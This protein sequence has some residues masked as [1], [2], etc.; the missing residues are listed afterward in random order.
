M[1]IFVS[2]FLVFGTGPVPTSTFKYNDNE[3]SLKFNDGLAYGT[4]VFRGK[5]VK[6]PATKRDKKKRDANHIVMYLP[7][8]ANYIECC[9]EYNIHPSSSSVKYTDTNADGNEVYSTGNYACI[10]WNVDSF[11]EYNSVLQMLFELNAKNIEGAGDIPAELS[12]NVSGL[13]GYEFLMETFTKVRFSE[14]AK[15]QICAN[16]IFTLLSQT[17][18]SS[19]ECK[20]TW[21]VDVNVNFL[22]HFMTKPGQN[23]G[24]KKPNNSFHLK[25][26]EG[27]N[28]KKYEPYSYDSSA[29]KLTAFAILKPEFSSIG[30]NNASKAFVEFFGQ[31]D[32]HTQ[33]RAVYVNPPVRF[34]KTLPQ[35]LHDSFRKSQTLSESM[36]SLIK[37]LFVFDNKTSRYMATDDLK[38]L[39]MKY[40]SAMPTVTYRKHNSDST[41]VTERCSWSRALGMLCMFC[42]KLNERPADL[43]KNVTIETNLKNQERA[44][45]AFTILGELYVEFMT[46][47]YEIFASQDQLVE[48]NQP[49]VAEANQPEVA[50]ADQPEVAKA[51]QPEVAEAVQTDTGDDG[52]DTSEEEDAEELDAEQPDAE[53]PDASTALNPRIMALNTLFAKRLTS[54]LQATH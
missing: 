52:E 27:P 12:S 48:A 50:K 18:I 51:D 13:K 25:E 39:V 21:A 7:F 33:K 37:D 40:K 36:K 54:L 4:R 38:A 6:I 17:E 30:F 35:H 42:S 14:S 8:C 24:R 1:N 23:V 34:S 41:L 47:A 29:W 53:Q 44:L 46:G 49:E 5:I 10:E 11:D 43:P 45:K 16:G 9:K 3:A 20:Q 31:D 32:G 2:I 15:E 28:G 26:L 19:D 22:T